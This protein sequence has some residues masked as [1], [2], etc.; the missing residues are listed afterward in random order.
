MVKVDKEITNLFREDLIFI[1]DGKKSEDILKKIGK[2]L[3]QKGLV[4]E[5]F[6]DEIIKREREYPTGLDLRIVDKEHLIPNVAIPHTESKYCK[7]KNIVV[8]KLKN[9]IIFNNMISPADKV[10]VKFLFIILNNEKEDQTNLL[11]SLMDFFTKK[12]NLH[13]LSKLENPR[14]IYNYIVKQK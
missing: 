11:G 7:V 9:E 8:V 5:Q 12:E 14:E 6:I 2:K 10:K 13:T 1:E 4:T 3:F